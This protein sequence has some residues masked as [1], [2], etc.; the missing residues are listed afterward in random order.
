MIDSHRCPGVGGRWHGCRVRVTAPMSGRRAVANRR[1]SRPMR[2]RTRWCRR[3]RLPTM[4]VNKWIGWPRVLPRSRS[5]RGKSSPSTSRMPRTSGP[6]VVFPPLNQNANP[7]P[8]ASVAPN[9]RPPATAA[10]GTIAATSR[11]RSRPWRHGISRIRRQTPVAARPRTRGCTFDN[12]ARPALLP[13]AAR[14]HPCRLRRLSLARRLPAEHADPRASTNPSHQPAP[15]PRLAVM[16]CRS[17]RSGTRRTRR[18]RSGCCRVNSRPCWVRGPVDQTRRP[19]CQG[20]LLSRDGRPVRFVRR[21]LPFLRQPQIGRR[22]VRRPKELTA[23]SL[24]LAPT[25]ANRPP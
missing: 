5:C 3:L 9:N 19:W 6:R 25:R 15:A 12:C 2:G 20:C 13:S 14:L 4:R 22:T 7:P 23:V 17:R 1:S 16:W 18:P 21:G 10:N 11:A 24:T 8:R